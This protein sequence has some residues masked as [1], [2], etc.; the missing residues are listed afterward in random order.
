MT[1]KS[2]LLPVVLTL[3][4]T[5]C[6]GAPPPQQQEQAQPKPTVFDPLT[7]TLDRAKAVQQTV[8]EQAA[9]QR[10]RIEQAER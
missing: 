2:S 5:A 7:S 3:V 6:S 1:H 10:K 9:E 4:L 8:D